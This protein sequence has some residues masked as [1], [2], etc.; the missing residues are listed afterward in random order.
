MTGKF[1]IASGSDAIRQTIESALQGDQRTTIIA[2]DGLEVLDLALDRKPD[3]IFLSVDLPKVDGVEIARALRALGPTEHVPIIFL[4]ENENEAKQIAKERL[5]FTDSLAA[6]YD[7]KQIQT[8]AAHALRNGERITALRQRNGDVTL[9]AISDPLT[10][11]YHRRYV[12]NRLAY[13]A[14][15]S[16]RYENALAVLLVDVDNLQ[17]INRDH[18]III[19]DSVMIETA[20]ALYKL[21][22]KTDIIGRYD[23][24]DFLVILP[25]T[26]AEG[27]R[28]LANRICKSVAEHKFL[29]GKLDLRIT[30][31]VGVGG[32]DGRD[33]GENLALIGRAASALDKAKQAGKN[34]V[35]MG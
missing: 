28:R 22:R 4:A 20:Q 9:L 10:Y 25:E 7:A 8:H 6:P 35:E 32:T 23:Q 2:R 33:L 27:A 1:L 30:V 19:G 15:R 12:V 14:A 3:A 5:P 16:A 34:R 13:E 31:S 17:G 26:R 24:Q 18:G 21:A 29:S 11:V